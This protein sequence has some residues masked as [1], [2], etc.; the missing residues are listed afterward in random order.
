MWIGIFCGGF[1]TVLLMSYKVKAA[2]I[3]GIS[4]V[5]IISWP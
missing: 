1:L 4:V 2:I 5:S 3:V